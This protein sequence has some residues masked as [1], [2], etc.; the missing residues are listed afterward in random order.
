MTLSERLR[1]PLS[2][3]L[4]ADEHPCNGNVTVDTP[5]GGAHLD[6]ERKKNE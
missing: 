3:P 4:L 1:D 6:P 2:V 5:G